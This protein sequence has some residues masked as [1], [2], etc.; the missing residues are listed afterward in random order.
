MRLQIYPLLALLLLISACSKELI[1][2]PDN[3][4]PFVGNVSTVK[5]ENYVNRLFIDNIGREPIDSEMQKE[6]QALKDA[7]LSKEAREVLIDKL[8]TNT[9]FLVGDTSYQQAYYQQLYTLAKIRCLEGA[10][11]EAIR[12]FIGI[13]EGES[14]I[15]RLYAVLNTRDDLMNGNIQFHEAF[16]RMIYNR[17]YDKINMNSFNFVNA[18]FDN[19]LWRF[20]SKV[21]FDAGFDM[22]EFNRSNT[23]FGKSGQNKGD[24]VKLFTESREMFEGLIIWAYQQL[25][26]RRPS[27]A[28]T[29]ALLA[30]FYENKNISLI[31]KK[32]MVTNEYANF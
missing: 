11:D 27:T 22:V 18:S 28:E 15:N 2:V 14:E 30:D 32:I 1:I 16:A 31:Q 8:Q 6:V 10:S 24:Y 20:P 23:L 17:V 25:V 12:G 13:A 3:D 26:A 21:E 4:P 5:I 19:L 7:N 9:D 29:V